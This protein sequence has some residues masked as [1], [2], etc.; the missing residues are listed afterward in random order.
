M[1]TSSDPYKDDHRGTYFILDRKS[2]KE[3]TPLTIGDQ[4]I[5]AGMSGVLSE[6]PDPTIFRRVLD[7]GCGTGGWIIEAAKTYP[8]MSLVGI[9]ISKVGALHQRGC[10]LSDRH[11]H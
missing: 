8:T 4:M 3:L 9:D 1:P 5:T 10:N 2:E 7:V 6:Q 11:L